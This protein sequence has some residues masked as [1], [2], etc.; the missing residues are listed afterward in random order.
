MEGR[1]T[2]FNFA[3]QSEDTALGVVF[4]YCGLGVNDHGQD[5]TK[6]DNYSVPG[7]AHEPDYL[8]DNLETLWRK[9]VPECLT[10]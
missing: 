10:S 6:D 8:G 2:R 7:G 5:E 9:F 1:K 3:S 4:T